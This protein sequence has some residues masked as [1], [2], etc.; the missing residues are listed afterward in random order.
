[1]T[2]DA[3][4]VWLHGRPLAELTKLRNG[5]LRLRFDEDGLDK[6]GVD[7][8][9]LSLA[10]PLTARRVEGPALD[11]FVLGL[12]PEPPVRQM[13]EVENK[14]PRGDDF[15]L[16]GA[17]GAECAGAVQ[18]LVSGD[19]PDGGSLR[20]L[21][22]D[23]VTD[24]VHNLPTLKTPDG[25]PVGA[26][27]GG[28]QA[29]VLLTK[30]EAGWAWPTGGALSTHIIKPEPI[31]NVVVP[32]L[33]E[34]EHWTA[35]LAAASGIR[36][37]ST[38]LQDFGGRLAIVV[39]RYDRSHGVRLHQEDFTQALGLGVRD[40]Y[41]YMGMPSRLTRI[42]VEAGSASIDRDRFQDD[43]LTLVAFNT[44]I[45]NSDAHSKNYSMIIDRAGFFTLAPLYDAAPTMLMNPSLTTAG[46]ALNGQADLRF[47]TRSNVLKEASLW[48]MPTTRSERIVELLCQTLHAALEAVPEPETSPGLADL[49]R[50]R[51]QRLL[52]GGPLPY[53]AG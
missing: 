20:A 23:E 37:A 40:K 34:A 9:A 38:E 12:L 48:G 33:V 21:S 42:A 50:K 22:S 8:R 28:T 3:L 16:L 5:R 31:A 53:Q 6:Y 36:A 14:V 29:K 26:S 13:I 41:E 35:N 24:I 30:A 47:V 4:A 44:L 43:L 39:E 46:H 27:L 15:A 25:L 51:I 45:G 1:M 7:S 10:L 2:Y 32:H 52:D 11:A 49:I 18:F 19:Q 17:I